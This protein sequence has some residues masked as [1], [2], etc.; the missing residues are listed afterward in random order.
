[1]IQV[2]RPERSIPA[3]REVLIPGW[4][5]ASS[6]AAVTAPALRTDTGQKHGQT[7]GENESIG[8]RPDDLWT[9]PDRSV[10]THW[11]F[12]ARFFFFFF[13]TDRHQEKHTGELGLSSGQEASK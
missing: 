6:P 13:C 3:K 5:T 11:C 4:R 7:D 9:P 1:M 10:S 2:A 12:L 8:R